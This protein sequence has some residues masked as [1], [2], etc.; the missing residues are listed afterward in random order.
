MAISSNQPLFSFR[1][2]RIHLVGFIF[3]LLSFVDNTDE[4]MPGGKH[5]NITAN[6]IY[7]CV[8]L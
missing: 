4:T 2:T 7:M 1:Y 5:D 3:Q 8:Y 6:Y